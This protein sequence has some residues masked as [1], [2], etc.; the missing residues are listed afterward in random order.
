MRERV[1]GESIDAAGQDEDCRDYEKARQK[2]FVYYIV[3][4]HLWEC[5]RLN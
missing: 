5:C 2:G 3:E 1:E 4:S